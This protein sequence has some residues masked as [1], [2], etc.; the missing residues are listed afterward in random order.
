[1][2]PPNNQ[3]A[4][5]IV[6]DHILDQPKLP[7]GTLGDYKAGGKKFQMFIIDT[8]DAQSAAFLV[9]DAKSFLQNPEYL[10]SFGGYFGSDGKQPVFIFSKLHYLAGVVGL[11]KS[12]ADPLARVLAS[13]LN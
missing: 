3:T 1:M 7:G 4:V 2:L 10:S 6:Q 13:R 9:M 11:P 8:E 12:E 5:R